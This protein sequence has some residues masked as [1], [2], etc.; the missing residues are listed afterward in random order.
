MRAERKKSKL[1]LNQTNGGVEKRQYKG[2]ETVRNFRISTSARVF[3]LSYFEH[4]DVQCRGGKILVSYW[5]SESV[6]S[7]R[8][9]NK[10]QSLSE[11]VRP[12]PERLYLTKANVLLLLT[13]STI[14]HCWD[15]KTETAP[16]LQVQHLCTHAKTIHHPGLETSTGRNQPSLD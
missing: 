15:E 5:S 12:P 10:L 9:C 7:W 16:T 4:A 3:S 14:S 13:E 8:W 2:E 11:S 6:W 1:K